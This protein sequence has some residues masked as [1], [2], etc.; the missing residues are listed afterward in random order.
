MD[1]KIARGQKQCSV[2]SRPFADKEKY[3][4]GLIP[5]TGEEGTFDRN[6]F[7]DACWTRQGPGA[8][9]AFWP[10]EYSTQKRPALLDPDLLWQVFHKARAA[11]EADMPKF[12]YV[13]ALGLMRLKKLK[14]KATKREGKKEVLVFEI[15]G[16]KA[17][18][19]T[20]YEILNPALDEKGVLDVQ[21]RLGD[22]A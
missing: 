22:M 4:V 11:G 3:F 19:R 5:R 13:A 16:A 17:K 2:C 20:Q 1:F 6:D 18:E 12:A 7:C 15:P 8:L 14:L 21:D 9:V 10:N